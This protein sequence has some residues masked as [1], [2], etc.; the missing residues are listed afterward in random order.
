MKQVLGELGEGIEHLR[1]A[2][3]L[4]LALDDKRRLGLVSAAMGWSFGWSGARMRRWRSGEPLK[5]SP[6]PSMTSSSRWQRTTPSELL[7][8]PG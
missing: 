3:S 4:A 7:P 6:R 8:S 2:E 1:E 5:R